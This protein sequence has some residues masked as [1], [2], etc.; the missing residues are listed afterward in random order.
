MEI[1]KGPFKDKEEDHYFC[2]QF[3][4]DYGFIYLVP[5]VCRCKVAVV[6]VGID[7]P[8]VDG[9]FLLFD[10]DHGSFGGLC[11]PHT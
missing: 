6:F 8:S 4:W 7:H 1:C 10:T 11:D 5:L 3:Y 2:D 9:F